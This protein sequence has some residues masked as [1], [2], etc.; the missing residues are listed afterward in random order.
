VWILLRTV[1]KHRTVRFIQFRSHRGNLP[2]VWRARKLNWVIQSHCIPLYRLFIFIRYSQFH[3][4]F[5]SHDRLKFISPDDGHATEECC[6][7]HY[8][9]RNKVCLPMYSNHLLSF[10]E[11]GCNIIKWIIINSL[12][13]LQFH[14]IKPLQLRKCH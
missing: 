4:I 9:F 5:W 3:N 12:F 8:I 2:Y 14:A 13:I 1:L 6:G 11:T 10:V 7:T